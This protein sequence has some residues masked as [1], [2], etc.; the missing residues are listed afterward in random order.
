LRSTTTNKHNTVLLDVM[1]L[2]WNIRR[3]MLARGELHTS[4]LA[5]SRIG[6]LGTHDSHSQADALHGR[7]ADGC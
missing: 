4:D 5:L 2:A 3:D 1:A 6:L 7:G